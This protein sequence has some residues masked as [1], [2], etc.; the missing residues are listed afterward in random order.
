MRFSKYLHKKIL[1][2]FLVL[3]YRTLSLW[4]NTEGDNPQAPSVYANFFLTTKPVSYN[5]LFF[6]MDSMMTLAPNLFNGDPVILV[7]G[8]S[9]NSTV[10]SVSFPSVPR[11]RPELIMFPWS[12]PPL[13]ITKLAYTHET[14]FM[15][16]NKDPNQPQISL[17]LIAEG[18]SWASLKR[19]LQ[20]TYDFL[21]LPR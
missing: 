10:I 14:F 19:W 9:P 20:R 21:T 18:E 15:M 7:L 16:E 17:V 1:M 4:A 11:V 5:S 6:T 8:S 3:F 2:F 13:D 12:S